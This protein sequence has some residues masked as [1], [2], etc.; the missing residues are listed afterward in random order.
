[1]NIIFFI[2]VA[3]VPEALFIFSVYFSL[4]FRLCN[5]YWPILMFDDSTRVLY[6]HCEAHL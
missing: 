3:Q 5:F 6:L 2:I 1:M 4:L